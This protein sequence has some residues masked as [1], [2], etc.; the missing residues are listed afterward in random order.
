MLKLRQPFH[1][2]DQERALILRVVFNEEHFYSKY[3]TNTLRD[4]LWKAVEDA[5]RGNQSWKN[6]LSCHEA[7]CHTQLYITTTQM[8][9]LK[10]DSGPAWQEGEDEVGGKTELCHARQ[11]HSSFDKCWNELVENFFF[12]IIKS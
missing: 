6:S 11:L 4:A 8:S 1:H 2:P 7:L 12:A 5:I 3:K 10:S 9:T